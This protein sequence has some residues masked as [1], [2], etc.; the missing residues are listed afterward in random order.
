MWCI[1][2][3]DCSPCVRQYSIITNFCMTNLIPIC[4]VLNISNGKKTLPSNP[5]AKSNWINVAGHYIKPSDILALRN[6]SNINNRYKSAAYPEPTHSISDGCIISTGHQQQLPPLPPP[7]G[8]QLAA[9]VSK[10]SINTTVN[11][12]SM[13]ASPLNPVDAATHATSQ[14]QLQQLQ[15]PAPTNQPPASHQSNQSSNIVSSN[16][17]TN[18][19]VISQSSASRKKNRRIGRHES[20]YTSGNN[21]FNLL[22]IYSHFS[23][24]NYIKH[25]SSF[26]P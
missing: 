5:Y 23:R 8:H 16:N 6:N 19:Q 4:V 14:L 2:A 17:S 3:F 9:A 10:N 26:C 20:R 25:I 18:N 11:A 1:I 7:S 22:I 12:S 13:V 15:T 21:Y 24:L